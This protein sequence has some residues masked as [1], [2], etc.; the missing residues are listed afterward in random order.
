MVSKS[1]SWFYVLQIPA[2]LMGET[3]HR[4][5]EILSKNTRY[6]ECQRRRHCIFSEELREKRN[7]NYGEQEMN[8]GKD[9]I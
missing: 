6:A 5:L 8:C 3:E 1:V 7:I 9:R 2:V 4:H